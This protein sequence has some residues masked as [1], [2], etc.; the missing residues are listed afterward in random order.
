M[1]TYDA[2]RQFA[3][4]WGLLGMM[5]FFLGVVVSTLGRH[6]RV[7]AENAARIPFDDIPAT[8]D[9][10]CGTCTGNE[11]CKRLDGLFDEERTHG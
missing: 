3:D 11:P 4:S 5:I 8:A 1:S 7:K 2:M 9:G 10:C 6:A